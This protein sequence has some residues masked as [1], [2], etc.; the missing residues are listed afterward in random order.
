VAVAL[1]SRRGAPYRARAMR[2]RL[3]A[4]ALLLGSASWT[5]A[6]E[7]RIA[8]ALPAEVAV[9]DA[10]I[11]SLLQ[12]GELRERQFRADPLVPGR[13]HQRLEQLALGLPVFGGEVVRQADGHGTVS[14]FGTLYDGIHLDPRPALSSDQG[15]EALERGLGWRASRR[16]APELLVLPLGHDG[17]A[18]VYRVLAWT[19]SD[20]RWC[21]VDAQSGALKLTLAALQAE[22]AVGRGRGVLNQPQKVSAQ[23]QAGAFVLSD[24]LRPPSLRTFDMAGDLARTVDVL[25]R[26]VQLSDSDLARDA[27]NDW[28]D[29]AAVDAHA[30]AGFVYDYYFKRHGRRGLDDDDLGIRSL[31][32]PARRGDE[33]FYTRDLVRLFYTNA[34]YAGDGIMVYGEGGLVSEGRDWDYVSGGLDIVGHE[35]S[36]GVTDFSSRLIY[37][38]VSGAL[39]EAFSD[40]MGTSIEFFFQPPGDGPLRADYTLGEDVIRPGGV[41]N[42]ADPLAYGDADHVSKARFVGTDTDGGG[43]HTNATI[44]GHA[45]F[46]AI[47]GGRNRTSGR[48]VRGVGPDHRD[49]IERAFY[50]AFVFL[51]PPSADYRTARTATLRSAR[52][53]YGPG[54]EAERAIAEAWT[55]VG[56]L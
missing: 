13:G 25:L 29:S 38:D 46:L 12:A 11:L 47:E 44:A 5:R 7:V 27:D 22:A 36:H 20:L 1:T 53:L 43:V 55:A 50:R 2:S 21:F 4:A 23:G 9:W 42:L 10:R 32:H 39:N 28:S 14:L 18:L 30:Y 54:S 41:R 45:F 52:D 37:R 8:A 3:L 49:E 6:G 19:G 16:V 56:V 15:R 33:R 48:S 24:A 40:I 35:L 31:V 51:L 34:F 17:A 26:D